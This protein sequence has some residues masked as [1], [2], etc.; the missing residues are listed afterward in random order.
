MI[1]S[2]AGGNGNLQTRGIYLAYFLMYSFLNTLWNYGDYLNT[3]HGVFY[4][5][6]WQKHTFSKK[7]HTLIVVTMPRKH[8]AAI[9]NDSINK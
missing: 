7:R 2:L 3:C 6:L 8:C 5:Q 1:R 9:S 4:L